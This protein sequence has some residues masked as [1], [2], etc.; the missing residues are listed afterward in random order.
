MAAVGNRD[1]GCWKSGWLAREPVG[2]LLFYK[3]YGTTMM[4]LNIC[5]ADDFPVNR[6]DIIPFPHQPVQ[7]DRPIM[8][9]SAPADLRCLMDGP[10]AFQN[11]MRHVEAEVYD[12]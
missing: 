6:C 2:K 4:K 12:D 5:P 3:E 11:V 9:V 1:G 7:R 10:F 8:P